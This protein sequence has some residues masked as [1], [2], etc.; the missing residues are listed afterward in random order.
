MQIVH[1]DAVFRVPPGSTPDY[2]ATTRCSEVLGLMER[3][4]TG[5][6]TGILP[7]R[8]HAVPDSVTSSWSCTGQPAPN[9]DIFDPAQQNDKTD[10]QKQNVHDF[11]T[12]DTHVVEGTGG[13][14]RLDR[15]FRAALLSRR[16]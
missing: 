6:R 16:T 1:S 4:A 5:R 7:G 3:I 8:A 14:R 2:N 13:C 15:A 10:F 12:T 9:Q 11:A